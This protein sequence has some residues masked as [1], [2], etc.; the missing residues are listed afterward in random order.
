MRSPGSAATL[1]RSWACNLVKDALEGPWHPIQIERID[2]ELPVSR[3]PT[4]PCSD[5]AP[6]LVLTRP[7]TPRRLVLEG[8]KRPEFTL[9]PD[10]RLHRGDAERTDQ[11]IFEVHDADIEA[12]FLHVESSEAG[13]QSG[14]FH[15]ALKVTELCLITQAR[16]PA[17]KPLSIHEIDEEVSD[18]RR[19]AHRHDGH[20][21]G[22]EIPTEAFGERIEGNLV[23]C[24]FDKYN[25]FGA[26]HAGENIARHE[27]AA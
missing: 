22:V 21:F 15:P 3:L 6:E 11:L 16:Q 19:A 24:S 27:S 20:P 7:P 13:A 1:R 10:D 4:G 9:P 17:G 25:C 12:K 5:E 18:G 2:Q 23:A 14:S 26:R 8:S